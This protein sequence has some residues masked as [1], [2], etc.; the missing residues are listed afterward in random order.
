MSEHEHGHGSGV[1]SE[2][3]RISTGKILLVGIVSLVIFFFASLATSLY[4]DRRRSEAPLRV[5]P[6]I[7][8]SK[9]GM[10]EQ[11]LFER[12]RRGE[13]DRM[14]RQERLRSY[15]WVDRR[16]GVVHLPIERAMELVAGGARP[17]AGDAAPPRPPG[18]QP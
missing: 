15:G 6:E 18:G 9:I 8:S 14:V 12:S 2:E 16:Q 17:A 1:R 7:G 5:P 13:S 3:D 4:F 10:V 11:Q